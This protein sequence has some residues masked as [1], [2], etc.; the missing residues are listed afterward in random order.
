MTR[1]RVRVTF[2]A[3]QFFSRPPSLS[4]AV[5]FSLSAASAPRLRWPTSPP[6]R[7]PPAVRICQYI[8]WIK[9]LRYCIRV[10]KSWCWMMHRRF[11]FALPVPS[12]CQA[13]PP[14]P[15]RPGILTLG[16]SPSNFLFL[17][18]LHIR[19]TP[20]SPFINYLYTS[21]RPLACGYALTSDLDSRFKLP[22]PSK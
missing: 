21:V 5:S 11:L 1:D 9:Y 15:L 17:S 7:A 12:A 6:I 4:L 20:A 16:C 14:S 18:Y 2:L 10:E 8:A 3:R 13:F 22:I 19:C